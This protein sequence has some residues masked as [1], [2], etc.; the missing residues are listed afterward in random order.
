MINEQYKK[1]KIVERGIDQDTDKGMARFC[2]K[3]YS[4]IQLYDSTII[5]KA[6][7]DRGQYCCLNACKPQCQCSTRA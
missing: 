1:M 5:C 7:P 3:L 2:I 4:S 6:S